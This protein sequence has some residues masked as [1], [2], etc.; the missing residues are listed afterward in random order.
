MILL[1]Y[2]LA[3]TVIGFSGAFRNRCK[4]QNTA[5]ALGS[6]FSCALRYVFH[7]ISGATVWAGLSIPTKA[8]L[9]YSLA[10]NATFLVPETIVLAIVAYYVG[11]LLDFRADQPV[12]LVR[13]AT[14]GSGVYKLIGWLFIAGAVVFDIIC[15]FGK[16]QNAETGELDFAGLSAL[17]RGEITA[18]ICVTACAALAVCAF[19]VIA[20]KKRKA[21]AAGVSE[22]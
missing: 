1:D 2:I 14:G 5:F 10:Y 21:S 13:E 19:F 6:V 4:K 9:L 12:R 16:L 18:M 17:T 7:V 20:A 11:S 15:V 8:A 3:Y 22:E